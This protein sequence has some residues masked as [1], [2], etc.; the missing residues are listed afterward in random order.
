M[1]KQI[2]KE[3]ENI[4]WTKTTRSNVSDEKCYSMVMGLCRRPFHEGLHFCKLND[5]YPDL[6][7]LLCRYIHRKQ[8]EFPFTTITLNKNLLCKPHQDKNNKGLS[9]I[10]ALG[11][12]TGGYLGIEDRIYDIHNK[13]LLFDGHQTHYT[14]PF[15]GNRYSIV[16]YSHN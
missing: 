4:N 3:L 13:L 11:N 7:D 8:P 15:F 5:I 14:I 9:A 10:I 12:F 6:Y 2:L 16:W 1:E